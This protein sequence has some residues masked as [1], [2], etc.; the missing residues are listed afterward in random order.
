[1]S[2]KTHELNGVFVF[3][4]CPVGRLIESERDATDLLSDAWA[5]KADLLAVPVARLA[6]EVFTLA[7]VGDVT[8]YV[9]ASNAPRDF[10]RESNCGA[11]VWFVADM[12]ALALRLT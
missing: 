4:V 2:D 3:E 6:P 12:P 1:M 9:D 7:I 10:V 8:A 5:V 11:G